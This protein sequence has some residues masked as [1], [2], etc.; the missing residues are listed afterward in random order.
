MADNIRTEESNTKDLDLSD[1][2][3]LTP[4]FSNRFYVFSG[5]DLSKILGIIGTLD[6]CPQIKY[7]LRR[8]ETIFYMT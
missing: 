5:S 3:N 4:V 2:G 7:S 8:M 1:F 6:S